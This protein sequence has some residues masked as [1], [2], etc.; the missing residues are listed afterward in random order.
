MLRVGL[1]GG[2]ACG[3]ST[4]GQLLAARGAH[5]LQADT[6]AHRLYEPGEPVYYAVVERFGR[7]ILNC[8]GSI[9]RGRLAN[10]AFPDRVAELNA[11]VHPAVVEAQTRW[12]QDCEPSDPAGIAVVEAAL[13]IEAG[14]A[15]DFDKIVVVTCTAEQKIAR[16]AQRARI[17]LEAAGAEVARRSA[18]QLSDEEKARHADFVIDNSGTPE[19]TQ[20]QVESLWA[21][22]T[23]LAAGNR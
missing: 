10:A 18:A 5:F 17:S 6:L 13:L 12:M 14:A 19:E 4:I 1:T 2:V 15:K 22:L 8:D 23:G 20:Q 7:E 9:N 11:I 16:Y 21:A 3:K